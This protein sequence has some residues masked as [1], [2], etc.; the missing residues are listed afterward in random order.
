MKTNNKKANRG[1]SLVELMVA[2]M[3]IGALAAIAMPQYDSYVARGRIAEGI[4]VLSELQLRQEQYYQD[5]RA[6]VNGM[7]PRVAGQYWGGTCTTANTNQTF[8]CTATPTATSGV[9]YIFT[10]DQSGAKTTTATS[11]AIAGWTVPSPATCWVKS[12]AGTC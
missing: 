4:S 5:N 10:V 2:V 3:I 11:P 12:K 7:T 8:I 1:F 6:Y 9:G